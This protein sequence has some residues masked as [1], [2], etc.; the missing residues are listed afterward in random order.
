MESTI[1]KMVA[2]ANT[3]PP[4]GGFG[5]DGHSRFSNLFSLMSGDN[6]HFANKYGK[7][8]VAK[9]MLEEYTDCHLLIN[10]NYVEISKEDYNDI[11]YDIYHDNP[12]QK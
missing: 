12:L 4:N 8:W 1:E 7:K 11:F 5:S 10:G 3:F 6:G 2:T 9:K